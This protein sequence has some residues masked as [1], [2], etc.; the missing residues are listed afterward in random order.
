[1]VSIMFEIFDPN[2]NWVGIVENY[3]S[4]TWAPEFRNKGTFAFS[5]PYTTEMRAFLLRGN[6][7]TRRDD[8]H[9]GIIRRV[10][11]KDDVDQ[12]TIEVS[13]EFALGILGQRVV[14]DKSDLVGSKA[15]VI[16]KLLENNLTDPENQ[17]RKYPL[18]E[19]D[20][21]ILSVGSPEEESYNL[22]GTC[23]LAACQKI[24]KNTNI[25]IRVV[26]K[27]NASTKDPEGL[28]VQLYEGVDRRYSQSENTRILFSD[29]VDNLYGS[30]YEQSSEH[31]KNVALV[32][33]EGEGENRVSLL[34]GD[35]EGID[36]FETVVDAQGQSS[37][38]GEITAEEYA[39]LLKNAGRAALSY[40]VESF[41]GLIV[42]TSNYVY[43]RDYN[44]GDI[45]TLYNS[46]IGVS[47]DARITGVSETE[48]EE[49]YSIIPI[50]GADTEI[51]DEVGQV[52]GEIQVKLYR[53]DVINNLTSDA[54]ELPLSAAMGKN[55]NNK[56][57]AHSQTIGNLKP[58]A[59][60]NPSTVQSTSTNTVPSDKLLKESSF[61][62]VYDSFTDVNPSFS[63][64]TPLLTLCAAMITGS[65]LRCETS[66]NAN[67]V[68]PTSYGL[69][70]VFK[71]TGISAVATFE[72]YGSISGVLYP[73][74][75]K[76]TIRIPDGYI[77]P[78]RK[79][80]TDYDISTVMPLSS[81]AA[82]NEKVYSEKLT[83]DELLKKQDLQYGCLVDTRS[84][85]SSYWGK[86]AEIDVSSMSV[87][88]VNLD[89]FVTNNYYHKDRLGIL[90]LGVRKRTGVSTISTNNVDLMWLTKSVSLS[91]SGFV[92][93]VNGLKVSLYHKP[94]NQY[95]G[96]RFQLV[97]ATTAGGRHTSA[98]YTLYQVTNPTE[99]ALPPNDGT[100]TPTMLEIEV[101]TPTKS[102]S[103]VPKSLL[104][105]KAPLDS[106]TFTGT[107]IV[108]D[109]TVSGAAVNKGQMDAAIESGNPF[110]FY[111]GW[112]TSG[113]VAVSGDGCF[114]IM[115]VDQVNQKI[116]S[117]IVQYVF[118][119]DAYSSLF[120]M[121]DSHAFG[122]IKIAAETGVVT[123]QTTN[124]IEQSTTWTDNTTVE[125]SYRKLSS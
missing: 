61:S 100:V 24:I 21:D 38:N 63:D 97:Q 82:S 120:N 116:Y 65:V 71:F 16:K 69:L 58:H 62:R 99:T 123:L 108:P 12:Q 33:G 48:D 90:R 40:E 56:I 98:Y 49:G 6:Y 79:L 25:G 64:T 88:D 29:T 103:P 17:A 86:V 36:R 76:A 55:L 80:V 113:T 9:I 59:F 91:S 73:D 26:L 83:Y 74:F 109:A 81:A 66:T 117:V 114:Q 111:W 37:D 41:A 45:I 18:V 54:T 124:T 106:P 75:Y 60:S 70:T 7:V 28:V 13:G 112:G 31:L 89:F 19:I 4:A 96:T 46:R 3:I 23:L 67:G 85:F 78:W 27:R 119:W 20:S 51:N 32:L 42:N 77:S 102:S 39:E 11:I 50:L 15:A 93:V 5:V 72:R 2:L 105:L 47:V 34:V 44:I 115:Y 1:M 10:V 107:V 101:P 53:K 52:D 122:R 92:A 121:S 68:Y 57:D 30:E 94:I 110:N 95:G 8:D 125:L 87:G 43:R 104:D 118:G 14:L 84:D 22:F 35:A